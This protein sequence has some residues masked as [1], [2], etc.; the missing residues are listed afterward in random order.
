MPVSPNEP[1]GSLTTSP[2]PLFH[3][4]AIKLN[5][6]V[7][8]S[9]SPSLPPSFVQPETHGEHGDLRRC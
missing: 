9:P 2:G 8:S 5:V 3:N 7:S 1:C 4:E 6:S